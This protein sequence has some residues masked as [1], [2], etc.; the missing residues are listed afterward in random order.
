MMDRLLS[1][2]PFDA[3]LGLASLAAGFLVIAPLMLV[4]QV[5][6]RVLDADLDIEAIGAV[7]LIILIAA[8]GCYRYLSG[9]SGT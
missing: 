7:T 3:V 1:W 5:R 9:Q 8:L 4:R 2:L 6:R